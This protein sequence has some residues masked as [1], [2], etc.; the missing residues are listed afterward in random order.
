M[1]KLKV[2]A[3]IRKSNKQKVYNLLK[4]LDKF[5]T[6][7]HNIKKLEI[8]N[9]SVNKSITSWEVVIDGAR[10]LWKEEDIFNDKDLNIKFKMLE[11]DFNAYEGEWRLEDT[12]NGTKIEFSANFD[13]GV[14][15][16]EKLVGNILKRKTRKALKS[17]LSAIKH[18]LEKDNG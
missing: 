7:M 13:W 15:A 5:P 12:L 18:K 4:K 10:L 8:V 1:P 6:F 3:I 9:N 2:S 17:M 14:P 11:G 16:L